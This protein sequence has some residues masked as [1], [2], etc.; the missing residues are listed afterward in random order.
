MMVLACL[1]AALALLVAAIAGL[2]AW[3]V[4]QQFLALNGDASNLGARYLTRFTRALD[5]SNERFDN[6]ARTVTHQGLDQN[7]IAKLVSATFERLRFYELNHPGLRKLARQLD[8]ADAPKPI[9]ATWL[10]GETE[11]RQAVRAMADG[12]A[13]PIRHCPECAAMLGDAEGDPAWCV[14]CGY[15]SP[16]MSCRRCGRDDVAP[17]HLA[18][19]GHVCFTPDPNFQTVPDPK[20]AERLH[21]TPQF[22]ARAAQHAAAVIPH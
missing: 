7:D 13:R 22:G 15:S 5:T 8:R 14:S 10:P 9:G 1:V 18:P 21:A 2:G 3:T 6:L 4:R 12:E 16:G 17:D 20:R 11:A 19:Q